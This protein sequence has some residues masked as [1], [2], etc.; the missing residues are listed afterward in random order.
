MAR[1]SQGADPASLFVDTGAWLAFFS[2][3]DGHHAEADRLFR[4][5]IQRKIPLFTSNLILAEVHRLL[6]FRAGIRPASAALERIEASPAVTVKFADGGI[7]REARA[8]LERLHDQVISYTDASSFA[9]MRAQRCECALS[10][11]QDF[12]IAGFSRWQGG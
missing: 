7:H 12:V 9:M 8:W 1:K 5:A 6:L 11:D 4:E 2:A 3:R 10:F